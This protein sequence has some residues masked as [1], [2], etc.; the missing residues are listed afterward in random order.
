MQLHFSY[1]LT[2]FCF[3]YGITLVHSSDYYPQGN[4][5]AKSSNKNLV[6]IICK[7]V[8]ENQRLLQ[9]FLYDTLWADH[10][11]P[12]WAIGM[13]SFQLLYGLDAKIPITLELPPLKLARAIEHETYPNCMDKK[14]MFLNQLE[15]QCAQVVD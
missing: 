7:L 14:I 12:K 10:I 2:Q 1:E 9:K 4:G 3:E 11:T 8:D 5:Q 13:S 6:S 15:E